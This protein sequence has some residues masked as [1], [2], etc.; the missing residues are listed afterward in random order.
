MKHS[1]VLSIYRRNRFVCFGNVT[2]EGLIHDISPVNPDPDTSEYI[3]DAIQEEVFE[4]ETAGSV[5]GPDGIYSW[6]IAYEPD[7]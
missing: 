4:G 1:P 6:D 5:P 7:A 2:S 3:L